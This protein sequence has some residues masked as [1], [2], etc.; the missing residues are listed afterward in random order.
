MKSEHYLRS[1]WR[2]IFNQGWV[3]YYLSRFFL[4]VAWVFRFIPS[5]SFVKV[6]IYGNKAFGIFLQVLVLLVT[7]SFF[8]SQN[9]ILILQQADVKY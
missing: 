5:D 6:L 7:V 8:R 1:K 4:L 2:R 9:C 3:V